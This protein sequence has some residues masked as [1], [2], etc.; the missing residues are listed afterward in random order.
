M[1]SAP[2]E[3]IITE[4][5]GDAIITPITRNRVVA[6]ITIDGIIARRGND[7]FDIG[8]FIVIIVALIGIGK[9]CI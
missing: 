2:I 1:P 5:T 3:R 7:V 8:D 6:C 9:A 4:T